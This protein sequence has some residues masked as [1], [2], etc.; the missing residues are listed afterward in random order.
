MTRLTPILNLTWGARDEAFHIHKAMDNK[1]RSDGKLWKMH[2]PR[3]N[4]NLGSSVTQRHR[5]HHHIELQ[6]YAQLYH[7]SRTTYVHC[8]DRT[9]LS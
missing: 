9:N 5:E 1:E 7:H 4:L 6:Y 8:D 3:K 2:S